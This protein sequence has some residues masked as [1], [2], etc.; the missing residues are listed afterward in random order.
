MFA[1]LS[2]GV[3]SDKVF[4]RRRSPVAMF[5]YFLGEVRHSPRSRRKS[6]PAWS[7]RRSAAF[8][9][10]ACSSSSSR[11]PRSPRTQLSAGRR[12]WTWADA[13][14]LALPPAWW[15]HSILRHRARAPIDR[16]AEI[17]SV[18]ASG[19]RPW[20]AS[21]RSRHRD[22]NGD[23]RTETHAGGRRHARS[24]TL[25]QF[26]LRCDSSESCRR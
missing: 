6:S 23:A 26:Q 16:I 4:K 5:L 2:A 22:V 19:I 21:V 15:T 7:A 14:W 1:A 13:R 3:I 8:S 18:G 20:P 11:S 9:S 17:G 24:G 12:P 25:Q 10:A